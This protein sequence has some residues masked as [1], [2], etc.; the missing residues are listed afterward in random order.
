MTKAYTYVTG[1]E[2]HR[3]F[4]TDYLSGLLLE[5][6]IGLYVPEGAD[7]SGPWFSPLRHTFATQV[8]IWMM[9]GQAEV[10]T[11]SIVHFA[12]RMR[13]VKGNNVRLCEV[14]NAPHDI[15][16]GGHAMGWKKE[17]DGA[18]KD[19]AEFLKNGGGS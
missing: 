5:W 19:A 18:A 8:P 6:G 14:P 2:S 3:N 17:A 1:V 13:M 9:A 11:D 7:F 4:K 10:L 12:N 16:M 15:L